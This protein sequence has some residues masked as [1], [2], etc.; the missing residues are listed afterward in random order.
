MSS[1]PFRKKMTRKGN[2]VIL[3]HIY[4]GENS[5][6]ELG[7]LKRL[8]L[9]SLTWSGTKYFT[10]DMQAWK[11]ICFIVCVKLEGKSSQI[12]LFNF[13]NKGY[14]KTATYIYCS[15]NW[16]PILVGILLL[17]SHTNTGQLFVHP[18]MGLPAIII[19]LK[20][21]ILFMNSNNT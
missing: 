12:E 6:Q 2:L 17:H 8:F 4:R 3:T 21:D 19:S 13:L 9:S 10:A 11:G 16:V 1:S 20:S 7:L 14:S 15:I 18:S 5:R